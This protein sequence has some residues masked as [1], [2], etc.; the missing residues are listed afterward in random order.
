MNSHNIGR[1]ALKDPADSVQRPVKALRA[2]P[3]EWEMIS[4]FAQIVRK[5]PEKATALLLAFPLKGDGTPEQDGLD[6]MYR[7]KIA[8]ID[9][10]LRSLDEIAACLREYRELLRSRLTQK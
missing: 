7:E 6:E 5:H 9:E 8:R 1:P 2:F 10:H 3:E 4:S